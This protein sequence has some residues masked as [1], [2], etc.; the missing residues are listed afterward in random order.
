MSLQ[1]LKETRTP[2]QIVFDETEDHDEG[3]SGIRCP[4]CSWRPSESSRWTCYWGDTPEP[5]FH[6]CGTVW[7]T[8]ATRGR[9]PGCSHQWVWTSCL[10]CSQWSLHANWYERT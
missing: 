7:N 9:C 2:D 5:H 6:S 4:R 1:V 3:L 10:R 8:F